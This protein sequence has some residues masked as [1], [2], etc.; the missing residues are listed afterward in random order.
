MYDEARVQ[1][2]LKSNGSG[3]VAQLLG[4]PLGSVHEIEVGVR[5][6]TSHPA[7]EAKE[8]TSWSDAAPPVQLE[9]LGRPILH[10]RPLSDSHVLVRWRIGDRA[11][12]ARTPGETVQV[13]TRG[14][15][16]VRPA[17]HPSIC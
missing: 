4:L 12:A 14:V 16:L 13:Y 11:H 8:M 5:F 2:T 10:A 3:G 15:L 9:T 6:Q 7:A 17:Q 1:L